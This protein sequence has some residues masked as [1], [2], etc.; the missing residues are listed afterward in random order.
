MQR[1]TFNCKGKACIRL[2]GKYNILHKIGSELRKKGQAS[3][4]I[5]MFKVARNMG[6]QDVKTITELGNCFI[7][8][9]KFKAGYRWLRYALREDPEN[10]AIMNSIGK[11]YMAEGQHSKARNWFHYALKID[12]DNLIAFNNLGIAALQQDRFQAARVHLNKAIKKHP[13][14]PAAYVLMGI[15]YED[16]G[17]EVEAEKWFKKV[18]ALQ[19][20]HPVALF[21]LARRMIMLRKPKK[22]ISYLTRLL[23]KDFHYQGLR[24]LAEISPKNASKYLDLYKEKMADWQIKQIE[25][26]L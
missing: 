22:A 20:A 15:S 9:E 18:L 17:N 16:Q 19:S 11:L 8:V 6:Y 14:D 3:D 1:L 21:R 7:S 2:A 25:E 12:P 24:T 4:A 23:N 5:N 26:K 13:K 10:V